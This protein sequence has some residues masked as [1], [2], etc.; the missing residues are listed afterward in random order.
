MATLFTFASSTIPGF[1]TLQALAANHQ[2]AIESIDSVDALYGY[3]DRK[4][5]VLLAGNP[6]KLAPE[7]GMIRSAAP[8]LSCLYV[9][10]SEQIKA[11][12]EDMALLADML[13]APFESTEALARLTSALQQSE[14]RYLIDESSHIDELTHLYNH[15]FF[16][17][18]LGQEMALARRHQSPVTCA[19]L[20]VAQYDI[21]QD[22]YGFG[23]MARLLRETARVTQSHVRK[24]D[25]VARLGDNEI[26]LLL[27][28]S[29]EKGAATLARR[30]KTTLEALPF[31]PEDGETEHV[32]ACIGIASFPTQDDE[33]LDPDTLI[34]YARH[35]LHQA[36]CSEDNTIQLF[37]QLK[38]M[39]P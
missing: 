20:S 2:F 4:G 12:T 7:V 16:L 9:L 30:I 24:E 39:M 26:A 23:F 27:P 35:A 8:L 11:V 15:P 28:H 29:T 17:K 32:S 6:D 21:F 22:C 25:I 31:V 36:R 37:S 1:D 13:V 38:P 14:L 19:I 10:E 33:P 34:R 18:R 3:R 5:V